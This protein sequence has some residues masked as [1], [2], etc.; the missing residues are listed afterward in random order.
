MK[1]RTAKG[2]GHL[3]IYTDLRATLVGFIFK[4]KLHLIENEST[5]DKGN[6]YITMSN[7]VL[8]SMSIKRL[9]LYGGGLLSV[10]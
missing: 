9:N 5:L 1:E 7:V 10:T 4:S 6:I 8:V 3:G 2:K